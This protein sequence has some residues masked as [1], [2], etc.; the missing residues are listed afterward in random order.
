MYFDES[1]SW[2]ARSSSVSRASSISVFFCS[3]SRVLLG[4]LSRLLLELVVR[5][6]QLLLL[7][8]E[9]LLG[10]LERLGLVLELRVRAPQLL[11]LGLELLRA[12]LELLREA[13]GLL[14]PL[15]RAAVRD[16]R[17]QDDA[18]R[19]RELLEEREVDLRV[20]LQPGELHDREALVLEEDRQHDEVDRG[21]LAEAGDD[22]DVV[23]GRAGDE[24]ALA[25]EGRLAGQASPKAKRFE[26]VLRR[27]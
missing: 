21:G 20:V 7:G 23:A 4:E 25:L 2:A 27:W 8:L 9:Q 24:D 10:R 14:E 5:L 12:A 3:M 15:L 22:L 6:A 1:E 11:L 26:S 16:D 19:L 17:R 13:L 18:D